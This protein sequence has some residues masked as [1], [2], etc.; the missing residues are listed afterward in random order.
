[1]NSLLAQQMQTNRPAFDWALVVC[2]SRL[3]AARLRA[4]AEQEC[5]ECETNRQACCLRLGNS[6]EALDSLT[7]LAEASLDVVLEKAFRD[8]EIE[9]LCSDT[10]DGG[11]ADTGDGDPTPGTGDDQGETPTGD[12]VACCA[13]TFADESPFCLEPMTA[14]ECLGICGIPSA[15]GVRCEE[16]A[17][18]NPIVACCVPGLDGCR[19]RTAECCARDGG[20]VLP[21]GGDCGDCP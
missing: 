5:R 1:M 3:A 8:P 17:C 18:D 14:E 21:E 20:T 2:T 9:R 11:P 16:V 13:S 15:P 19:F 7:S 4:A 12:K 10:G 6:T